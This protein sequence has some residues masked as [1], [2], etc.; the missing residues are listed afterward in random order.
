MAPKLAAAARK[1]ASKQIGDGRDIAFRDLSAAN[2]GQGCAH[3]VDHDRVVNLI[4]IV[5]R[6]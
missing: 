2:V 4:V 5:A 1:A 3:Y 6:I